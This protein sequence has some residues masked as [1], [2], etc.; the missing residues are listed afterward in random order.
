MRKVKS[1]G[2]SLVE[3]MVVV[4]IIGILSSIAIPNFKK[5]QAK[6]RQTE[7][8]TNLSVIHG[9]QSSYQSD[10]GCYY[11]SNS[12]ATGACI[13][14]TNTDGTNGG[15]EAGAMIDIGGGIAQV[16]AKTAADI[17]GFSS[18]DLGFSLDGGINNIR[19][20]YTVSSTLAV[21][22]VTYGNWGASA[23]SRTNAIIDGEG[24]AGDFDSW[25]INDAKCIWPK[26]DDV[27][28]SDD[29]GGK[30]LKLLTRCTEAVAR[31]Q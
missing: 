31:S 3:L 6:A 7:A 4:A 28:D 22:N 11:P 24:K 19:Y 8:K 21:A 23:T 16:N 20:I 30:Q 9:L 17:G 13:V 25:H 15:G 2:F 29:T 18:N 12:D 10:E 1:R 27:S 14:G 5:F 26:R